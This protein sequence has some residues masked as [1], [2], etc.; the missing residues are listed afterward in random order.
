MWIQRSRRDVLEEIP[1]GSMEAL[2][3]ATAQRECTGQAQHVISGAKST[4][5]GSDRLSTVPE[6]TGLSTVEGAL[7][8]I[9][10]K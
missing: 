5:S 8:I 3:F 6:T 10:V 7:F 4:K 1:E 2:P 9:V